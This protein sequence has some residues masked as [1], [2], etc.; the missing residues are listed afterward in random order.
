MA[1]HN[2]V[3]FLEGPSCCV[4]EQNVVFHVVD[5]LLVDVLDFPLPRHTLVDRGSRERMREPIKAIIACVVIID[6]FDHISL[7]QHAQ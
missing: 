5:N 6:E 4:V 2:H 1:H 7:F 3:L